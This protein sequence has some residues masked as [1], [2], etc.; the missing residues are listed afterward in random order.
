[1]SD[2]DGSLRRRRVRSGDFRNG[3]IRLEDFKGIDGPVRFCEILGMVLYVI[4]A[5]RCF[6]RA[7]TILCPHGAGPVAAEC[8][9]KHDIIVHEMGIDIAARAAYEA[10][11]GRAPVTWIGVGGVEISRCAAAGKGPDA[12]LGGGPFHR[13]DGAVGGA[14]CASLE[15]AALIALAIATG[16]RAAGARVHGHLVLGL[17]VDAFDDV[18][19]AAVWPVGAC[20][21]TLHESV[22][23]CW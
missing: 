12:D 4:L 1:M 7:G 19:L 15:R 8:S 10:A 21:P 23:Y 9:I 22:L 6:G 3:A 14:V 13:V 16:K 17:T 20:H 2:R 18:D 5:G 11:G